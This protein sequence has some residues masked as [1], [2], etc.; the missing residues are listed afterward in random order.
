MGLMAKQTTSPDNI[1][2][3]RVDL[4]QRGYDILIGESLIE[5]AGQYIFEL[6]LYL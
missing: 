5:N 2:K 4:G 1:E 6:Y 3:I